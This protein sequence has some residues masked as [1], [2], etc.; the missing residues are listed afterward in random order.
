MLDCGREREGRWPG[1]VEELEE[2]GV[3]GEGFVGRGGERSVGGRV[4]PVVLVAQGLGVG[5]KVGLRLVLLRVLLL[6]DRKSVV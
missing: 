2:R 3:E 6:L 5:V 4:E 1:G